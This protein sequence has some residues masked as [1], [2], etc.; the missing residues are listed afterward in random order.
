MVERRPAPP[1]AQSQRTVEEPADTEI[2]RQ[3][4]QN[5]AEGSAPP[6]AEATAGADSERDARAAAV[7]TDEEGTPEPEPPAAGGSD[8]EGAVETH[9]ADEG[10]PGSSGREPITSGTN[11][12]VMD[13]DRGSGTISNP[14]SGSDAS[15][16]ASEDDGADADAA[17]AGAESGSY[18]M[19]GRESLPPAPGDVVVDPNRGPWIISDQFV[20]SGASATEPD[21][22]TTEPGAEEPENV[23]E[24]TG[25]DP[26]P[27]DGTVIETEPDWRWPIPAVDDDAAEGADAEAEGSLDVI[28]L[29][30][31]STAEAAE[32]PVTGDSIATQ[33][34][35][36]QDLSGVETTRSAFPRDLLQAVSTDTSPDASDLPDD[37]DPYP[38]PP[39]DDVE[40]ELVSTDTL[41]VGSGGDASEW[42]TVWSDDSD[43]TAISDSGSSTDSPVED[44]DDTTD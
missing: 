6:K 10:A 36:E 27:D 34:G 12:I 39:E 25:E 38:A 15:A 28:D 13:S 1:R 2:G 31:E 40:G 44:T 22:D 20:A 3:T 24:P 33:K 29:P 8:D 18:G 5:P 35:F 26:E 16:P 19:V 17:D 7:V 4:D 11:Y 42:V 43:D 37:A 21:A 23:E 41:V 9:G 14:S 32:R 30:A